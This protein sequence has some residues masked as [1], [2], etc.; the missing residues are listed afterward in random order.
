[1]T[2]RLTVLLLEGSS[3]QVSNQTGV[4]A[5]K[6][7]LGA[8]HCSEP[9]GSMHGEGTGRLSLVGHEPCGNDDLNNDKLRFAC[10][11]PPLV[12][13]LLSYIWAFV[14]LS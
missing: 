2:L 7:K 10:F 13:L 11:D 14:K 9:S 6:V 5:C 4:R 3:K 12:F 8:A 1:M